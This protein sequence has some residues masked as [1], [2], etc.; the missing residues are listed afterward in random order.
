MDNIIFKKIW[1]DS[2][3]IGNNNNFLFEVKL[4]CSNENITVSEIYYMCDQFA[5]KISNA[6]KI[7]IQKQNEQIVDFT[8]KKENPIEG[9]SFKISPP[10]VHGHVIVFV[11]MGIGNDNKKPHHST[12]I[13]ETELGLLEIFGKKVEKMAEL[14]LNEEIALN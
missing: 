12:F 11:E 4:T 13:V 10:D 7:V 9:Y 14:E 5:K 6:I 3:E 1:N 2:G 8:N